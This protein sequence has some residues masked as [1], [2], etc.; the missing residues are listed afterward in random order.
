LGDGVIEHE[1]FGGSEFSFNE[2]LA[3]NSRLYVWQK[4]VLSRLGE[5][6]EASLRPGLRIFDR[7]PDPELANAWNF[8]GDVQQALMNLARNAGVDVVSRVVLP[9]ADE[10]YDD[11]WVSAVAQ[12][13]PLGWNLEP[14]FLDPR[15]E[16]SERVE[17]VLT[18][19]QSHEPLKPIGWDGVWA[20]MRKEV[21]GHPSTEPGTQFFLRG[22]GH[23]NERGHALVAR[24]IGDRIAPRVLR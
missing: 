3:R 2:W 19:P 8:Q 18:N 10:V 23:L 4:R 21:A 9:S 12:A 6:G 5:G 1:P 24:V 20:E 14:T 11:L 22:T 17:V 15:V 16:G 7:S 13:K